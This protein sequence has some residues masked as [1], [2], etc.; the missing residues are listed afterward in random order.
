MVS[1]PPIDLLTGFNL[2]DDAVVTEI[3]NYLDQTK[4]G[5]IMVSPPCTSFSPLIKISAAKTDPVVREARQKE[6]RKL[7][8]VAMGF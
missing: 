7:L 2:C 4:P 6:G 1:G 5:C 3:Y 8:T